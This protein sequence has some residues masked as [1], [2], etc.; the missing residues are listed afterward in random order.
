MNDQQNEQS[1]KALVE[2]LDGMVPK[3][4]A[5]IE[6]AMYGGGPDESQ[7][8]GD[9]RGYLRL[10]IEFLKAAFATKMDP[11]S[12]DSIDVE[13]DYLISDNSDVS[14]DLFFRVEDFAKPAKT[15]SVSSRVSSILIFTFFIGLFICAVIGIGT[16]GR[17]I[18]S[19]F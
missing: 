5:H 19:L 9:Q 1:I 10:G 17:W 4:N 14:F 2:K 15:E 3:D 18:V 8:K 7:I 16:V 11:K 13:L 12:P 6:L